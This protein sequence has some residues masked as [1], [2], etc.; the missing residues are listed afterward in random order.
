MADV[1][2]P[3]AD[4][5]TVATRKVSIQNTYPPRLVVIFK[6]SIFERPVST[7]RQSSV[8]KTRFMATTLAFRRRHSVDNRGQL[9]VEREV[10]HDADEGHEEERVEQ[11]LAEHLFRVEC[12]GREEMDQKN[13]VNEYAWSGTKEERNML[14]TTPLENSNTT[15]KSMPRKGSF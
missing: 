13:E 8:V 9:V 4:E 11:N 5:E 14:K 7:R 12:E 15:V 10:E 2:A 6:C 1:N 3:E